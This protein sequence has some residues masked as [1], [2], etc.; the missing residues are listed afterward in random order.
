M[1]DITARGQRQMASSSCRSGGSSSVVSLPHR[2]PA[3]VTQRL[4]LQQPESTAAVEVMAGTWSSSVQAP[5]NGG[6]GGAD[7]SSSSPCE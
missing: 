6:K 7:G 4:P 3:S 5:I 2:P 1:K